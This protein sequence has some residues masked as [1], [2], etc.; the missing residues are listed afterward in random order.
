MSWDCKYYCRSNRA[1]ASYEYMQ[2]RP[3]GVIKLPRNPTDKVFVLL[4]SLS[5]EPPARGVS[6]QVYFA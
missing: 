1:G 5:L 6:W 4:L 3:K 2:L